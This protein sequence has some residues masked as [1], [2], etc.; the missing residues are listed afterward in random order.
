MDATSCAMTAFPEKLARSNGPSLYTIATLASKA[1]HIQ[2]IWMLKSLSKRCW[3]YEVKKRYGMSPWNK[4]APFKEPQSVF[5]SYVL[6]A[7]LTVDV[8]S[9][10]PCWSRTSTERRKWITSVMCVSQDL[11][12]NVWMFIWHLLLKNLLVRTILTH[13][14]IPMIGIFP[15]VAG[16]ASRLQK[17][18]DSAGEP[19]M[20]KTLTPSH[21]VLIYV[22]DQTEDTTISCSINSNS[23]FFDHLE[24]H[25]QI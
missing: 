25:F 7:S 16:E 9:R 20:W 24:L 12:R 22:S 11:G 4:R 6:M 8:V 23:T 18:K 13:A 2:N 5:Y 15:T 21:V 19:I 3:P 14:G 1:L 17:P 10:L